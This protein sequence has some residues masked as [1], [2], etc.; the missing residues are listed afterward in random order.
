[1]A[2]WV[3]AVEYDGPDVD[4]EHPAARRPVL[5]HAYDLA[6]GCLAHDDGHLRVGFPEPTRGWPA[7][8]HLSRCATCAITVADLVTGIIADIVGQVATEFTRWAIDFTRL[9][10]D[11]I[12][13]TEPPPDGDG[14]TS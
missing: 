1:M 9:R 8:A 13:L 3:V 4:R 12:W 10:E 6:T 11:D 2:I 7:P 5:E 14:S